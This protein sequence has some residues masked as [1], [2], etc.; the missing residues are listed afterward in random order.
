MSALDA[1]T[2]G[3]ELRVS[4]TLWPD[5]SIPLDTSESG[6]GLVTR[7]LRPRVALVKD[8][9]LLASF[10]PAGAPEDGFPL[11]ALLIGAVLVFLLLT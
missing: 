4:S 3:A 11:W 9:V 10:Q 8:G 2:S 6:P 1:L 5:V 7:L